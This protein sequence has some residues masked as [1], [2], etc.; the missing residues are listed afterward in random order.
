MFIYAV[1][2]GFVYWDQFLT[3]DGSALG[4]YFVV[5]DY[6]FTIYISVG[7]PNPETVRSKVGITRL[8]KYLN[9]NH[10]PISFHILLTQLQALDPPVAGRGD[11]TPG[12]KTALDYI[13]SLLRGSTAL[14]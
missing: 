12:C 13:K 4:S 10:R 5:S 11:F 8:K 14:K 1:G 6:S 9:P 2:L 3:D 7:N